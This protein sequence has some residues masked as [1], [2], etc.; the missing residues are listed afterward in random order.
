MN[1]RFLNI[2]NSEIP[3]LVDF[4]AEWCGPCK[5]MPPILKEIKAELKENV[6]IIKVDVDKNP[7]IASA[8]RIQSIPTVIIFKNGQA[9]WTGVGL[10]PANELMSVLRNHLRQ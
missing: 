9:Q 8:Y 10:H 3:V 6:K 5:Q 7:M 4:Y 1:G 2:I